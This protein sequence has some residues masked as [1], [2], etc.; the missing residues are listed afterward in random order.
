L[1]LE[2]N[3]A[4]LLRILRTIE[5]I[6]EMQKGLQER[7]YGPMTADIQ[8]RNA[9]LSID[10]SD[11][12]RAAVLRGDGELDGFVIHSTGMMRKDAKALIGD[13]ALE[14]IIA[15]GGLKMGNNNA[16]GPGV[17]FHHRVKGMT[18]HG[19][20]N[21]HFIV[22]RRDMDEY[23]AN[24]AEDSNVSQDATGRVRA[25][26][27]TGNIFVVYDNGE[28]D[29]RDK[30]KEF[31]QAQPMT[32]RPVMVPLSI[33]YKI[34]VPGNGYLLARRAF[35]TVMERIYGEAYSIAITEHKSEAEAREAALEAE[36]RYC[37]AG[38]DG[39]PRKFEDIFV[40]MARVPLQITDEVNREY[41]ARQYAENGDF[42][43]AQGLLAGTPEKEKVRLAAAIET[44][45]LVFVEKS[46]LK[47]SINETLGQISQ[48]VRTVVMG[49]A[50]QGVIDLS[51]AYSEL[52]A[53]GITISTFYDTFLPALTLNLTRIMND[54]GL[55]PEAVEIIVPRRD[56]RVLLEMG[57]PAYDSPGFRT[58]L[59]KTY[60][61]TPVSPDDVARAVSINENDAS[62]VRSLDGLI[63][64]VLKQ[65][66]G[67][68]VY[69]GSIGSSQSLTY[70][71][72]SA[73]L[74]KDFDINIDTVSDKS[75]EERTEEHR[76]IVESVKDMVL[77]RI[78]HGLPQAA[79]YLGNLD[80]LQVTVRTL[81][82]GRFDTITMAVSRGP[83]EMR[84]NR[85]VGNN[86][87]FTIDFNFKGN[88]AVN[89]RR[90][91][92]TQ[93]GE[94]LAGVPEA[95]RQAAE[96]HIAE[97]VR[98]LKYMLKP[99]LAYG[100]EYAGL[101]GVS[102]EQLILLSGQ[103]GSRSFEDVRKNYNLDRAFDYIKRSYES[104]RGLEIYHPVEVTSAGEKQ[105]I[106][107]YLVMDYG[108]KDRA[109]GW[110]KLLALVRDYEA[111]RAG[112][113]APEILSGAELETVSAVGRGVI[114][115]PLRSAAI[116]NFGEKGRFVYD[117]F[118]APLWEEGVFFLAVPAVLS[119]IG[120]PVYSALIMSRLIFVIIHPVINVENKGMI[121]P[122]LISMGVCAFGADFITAAAVHMGLNILEES[123]KKASLRQAVLAGLLITLPA[124]TACKISCRID[125]GQVPV[126]MEQVMHSWAY[127]RTG[128]LLDTAD[129]SR[130]AFDDTRNAYPHIRTTFGDM[131]YDEFINHVTDERERAFLTGVL[132][133]C[134]KKW[135]ERM[136]ALLST[137]K[138]VVIF[139]NS[140]HGTDVGYGIPGTQTLVLGFNG[141]IPELTSENIG[142]CAQFFVHEAAHIYGGNAV[143]VELSTPGTNAPSGLMVK[144]NSIFSE[145]YARSAG[146]EWAE[147]AGD[148]PQ[149]WINNEKFM[150]DLLF[151]AITGSGKGK[152]VRYDDV[153][154]ELARAIWDYYWANGNMPA[155]VMPVAQAILQS[156]G[157]YEPENIKYVS[158]PVK[159]SVETKDGI[160]VE[161]YWLEFDVGGGR[162]EKVFTGVNESG[163]IDVLFKGK[164]Y[165]YIMQMEAEPEGTDGMQGAMDLRGHADLFDDIFMPRPVDTGELVAWSPAA[166]GMTG[167][168]IEN[169]EG[170]AFPEDMKRRIFETAETLADSESVKKTV[171]EELN[172]RLT[173]EVK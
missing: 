66:L 15:H 108:R 7:L 61:V 6:P 10:M 70:T 55:D 3:A 62:F 44:G 82:G 131:D 74:P 116:R 71:P 112:Q 69:A 8:A 113:G 52:M 118:I 51:M 76:Q 120:M 12:D 17:Y 96:D 84:D 147:K 146:I 30:G 145:L 21:V 13:E 115:N 33:V 48:G 53:S 57:L 126:T 114:E 11:T 170:A 101:V 80:D 54:N 67:S 56:T 36:R 92:R 2:N 169:Y 109:W 150:R 100:V 149:P 72:L 65:R 139:E 14:N 104:T 107:E 117:S 59:Q 24:H 124:F 58:M 31:W 25:E 151:F 93:L 37:G 26:S 4:E 166:V 29:L 49:A 50:S 138:H 137:L 91:Y 46:A 171:M 140:V 122:A 32:G 127:G 27:G 153:T 22:R 135:P 60:G 63:V 94:H 152:D 167:G 81:R 40:S 47:T 43:R 19:H 42:E 134:M 90:A 172:G 154:D 20:E 102:C 98:M 173:P 144:D 85:F 129:M 160:P 164:W 159:K 38:A 88:A 23:T 83:C 168:A 158:K 9:L 110:A 157:K 119:C 89:Y 16:C 161:G 95:D 165:Q 162:V 136:G 132:D 75:G 143:M 97:Q 39:M 45:K 142:Q 121:M 1:N 123:L 141:R 155:P 68:Q 79:A 77:G 163:G 78:R 35:N 128:E 105:N 106:G 99:Y 148:M 5:G 103:K 34:L 111:F 156:E 41:A 130:S 87:L 86:I 28:I 125:P 73:G 64:D 133:Y 18:E